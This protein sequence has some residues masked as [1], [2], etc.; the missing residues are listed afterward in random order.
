DSL[1]PHGRRLASACGMDSLAPRRIP[2][3]SARDVDSSGGSL[4]LPQVGH[5]VLRELLLELGAELP[6]L[7][8]EIEHVE[9]SMAFR[10][11]QH[12]FDIAVVPGNDARYAIQQP[13]GILTDNLHD[14]AAS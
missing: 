4:V 8:R 13:K 3:P 14:R 2:R 6:A 10:V 11:D 7:V 9:R 5:Q 12:N 1:P